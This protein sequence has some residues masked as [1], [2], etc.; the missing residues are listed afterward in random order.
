MND[1]L[2]PLT[3]P[4][5]RYL[6]ESDSSDEEGQGTY[7]S[8]STSRPK[9]HLSS[10]EITINFSTAQPQPE[11][12]ELVLGL[13]QAGKYIT[14]SLGD[15]Q[16]AGE[17]LVDGRLVG[18]GLKSGQGLLVVGLDEGDLGNEGVWGLAEKLI[19]TLKAKRWT[20]ITSY[21]P[22]MYIPSRSER[23][24]A[25][26]D[27]AP[28][29]YLCSATTLGDEE[30]HGLSKFEAPNYLTGLAAALT[31]LSAHPS[32]PSI[33]ITTL[34][35]PLPLSSLSYQQLNTPL[36]AFSPLLSAQ[37]SSKSRSRWTEDDDEP[38][39]AFGM[40]KVRGVK[41]GVGEAASMYT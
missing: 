24:S 9:I 26:R 36:Q 19:D 23:A 29:R 33:Q 4:P 27:A 11:L 31:A 2:S 18:R 40:G 32:S 1:P 8:S 7:P 28:V 14:R 21:V 20:I 25:L 41:R 35:L 10:S 16:A 12:E 6:L 34:S 30:K 5:P 37:I 22:S 17:V 15:K 13:G 39:A 38:Y 3:V